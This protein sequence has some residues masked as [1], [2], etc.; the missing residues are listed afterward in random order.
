MVGFWI[1]TKARSGPAMLAGVA[2]MIMHMAWGC[3]F[4]RER[5]F[6]AASPVKGA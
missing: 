3:G 5:L 4:L 1:G 6:G 2:A